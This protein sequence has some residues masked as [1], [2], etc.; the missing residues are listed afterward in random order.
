MGPSRACRGES[1]P[2]LA[3]SDFGRGPAPSPAS[4]GPAHPLTTPISEP[5]PLRPR[6]DSPHLHSYTSEPLRPCPRYFLSGG[7][8]SGCVLP[9]RSGRPLEIDVRRGAEPVYHWKG[10]A[11]AFRE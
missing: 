10:L 11:S 4:P 8:T 6:P 2:D 3:V 5:R 1:E 7:L 9:V